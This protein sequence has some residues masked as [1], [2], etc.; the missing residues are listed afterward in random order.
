MY[1]L[2]P[3]QLHNFSDI[4]II[5]AK[6]SAQKKM[7]KEE[8]LNT[9]ATTKF[10]FLFARIRS[11]SAF[12][13][14]GSECIKSRHIL[15]LGKDEKGSGSSGPSGD[16][17]QDDGAGEWKQQGAQKKG[18]PAQKSTSQEQGRQHEPSTSQQQGRPQ[19]PSAPQQHGR[20]QQQ[21]SSQGRQQQ[22]RRDPQPPS[23]QTAS[24]EEHGLRQQGQQQTFLLLIWLMCS[25]GL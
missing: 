1:Q 15:I 17:N 5:L 2:F 13:D 4:N 24:R 16:G 21:T 25:P 22:Q 20:Q 8:R 6:L 23:S 9:F 7:R 18:T 11:M 19:Q 10:F 3:H 12:T 14:S